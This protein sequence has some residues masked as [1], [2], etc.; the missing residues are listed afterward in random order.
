[1]VFS[2]K[3]GALPENVLQTLLND[4]LVAKGSV[5]HF[6]TTFFQVGGSGFLLAVC[7]FWGVDHG[8]P[9]LLV[10]KG[11]VMHFMTTFFQVGGGDE[12]GQGFLFGGFCWVDF[13]GFGTVAKGSVM[14]FMTWWVTW[15]W[16]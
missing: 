11:S 2:Y 15:W 1:M 5:M 3:L 7:C 8:A 16:G 10:A 9:L 4:R 14:H 6:M 13:G 12:Q